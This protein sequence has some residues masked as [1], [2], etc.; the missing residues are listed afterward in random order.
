MDELCRASAKRAHL[1]TK[2]QQILKFE[3]LQ[4]Q[5]PQPPSQL[6][7]TQKL[8]VNLSQKLLSPE[9]KN[10]LALGMSFA[11]APKQIPYQDIIT[12]TESLTHRIDE[13]TAHAL[14]LGVSSALRDA[15]P[16]RPNLSFRQRQVICNLKKDTSIVI[17]PADKGR[18]TVVMNKEDYVSKRQQVVRDE[19]YTALHRDPTVRTE[20]KTAEQSRVVTVQLLQY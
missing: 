19:K 6:L 13:R 10:V 18:V 7:D 15:R 9:E 11:I 12:A 17:L 8:V 4:S 2:T 16:P 5:K 20:R 14:K 1:S 3:K